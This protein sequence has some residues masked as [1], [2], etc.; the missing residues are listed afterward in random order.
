[1][2][3]GNGTGVSEAAVFSIPSASTL[4]KVN[5]DML[6]SACSQARCFRNTVLA[7]VLFLSFP[8]NERR[9]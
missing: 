4:P 9:S 3:A 6:L 8:F 2:L 1:M 5:K 7:A